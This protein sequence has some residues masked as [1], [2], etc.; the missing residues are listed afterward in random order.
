MKIRFPFS[1]LLVIDYYL[2]A[3]NSEMCQ[4]SLHFK[5]E[6]HFIKC[7]AMRFAIIKLLTLN[8]FSSLVIH[9]VSIFCKQFHLKIKYKKIKVEKHVFF[10]LKLVYVILNT[11]P[12]P[13]TFKN[14]EMHCFT[15]TKIWPGNG[16]EQTSYLVR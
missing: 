16:N 1:E 5:L 4:H 15:D 12:A 14:L 6:T 2:F 11:S 13:K 3:R 7:L 10:F 9:Y 8:S